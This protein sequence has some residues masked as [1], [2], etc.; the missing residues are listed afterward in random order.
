[1]SDALN[2]R[3]ALIMMGASIALAGCRGGG[4]GAGGTNGRTLVVGRAQDNRNLDPAFEG[5]L[6]DGSIMELAY[7]RLV[8]EELSPE[9]V[10]TGKFAGVLAEKWES[11]PSGLVWTFH[12]R[13]DH[14]FDDGSPVTA[15][16][17]DFSYKRALKLQ[18]GL[19]ANFFWLKRYAVVDDY[20]LR[21]E[22]GQPF[23]ILLNFLAV[24]G[25]FVN[26][27]VAAKAKDGDSAAAWL[28]ENS[29]GSGPY[30]VERWERGQQLVM[31]AN[32]HHPQRDRYFDRVVFRYIREANA[33]R[34]EMEKGRIDVCEGVGI[35]DV[36]RF[37]TISGVTLFNQPGPS[38][39]FVDINNRNPVLSDIRVRKALALAIDYEAVV[40]S[41]MQGYA[42]PQAGP[43]PIGMPGYDPTVKHPKRDVAAARALLAEAGHANAAFTLTYVQGGST[44][45]STVLM[46]QANLKEIGV[47]LTLEPVAPSAA[48]EKIMGG[49]YELAM[50]NFVAAIADPWLVTFPLF[51]SKNAGPGGNTAFYANP[52]VDALLLRAQSEP[53]TPARLGLY[54]EAQTLIVADVPRIF[55][56]S[57]NGL[58]AYRSELE[59][60]AYSAW[61]PLVYD[62]AA[63]RRRAG[64]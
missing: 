47:T 6:T 8:R 18:P 35:D 26:P 61:R 49:T 58:L 16:A 19:A 12:L 24:S 20:T 52:K 30:R 11:D 29:A 40:K 63:M 62:V 44:L 39:V 7:E 48:M 32:P 59:N 43:I 9:G 5:S 33:R 45:N 4:G 3:T 1:M 56:F 28:S 15:Q 50:N 64:G 57:A 25:V 53:D 60:V 27:A 10:P 46:I 41:V 36:E 42:T 55:L 51:F 17:F 22:L 54:R 2:R 14:K 37:K 23:P 21:F 34:L 31:V 13:R 38:M